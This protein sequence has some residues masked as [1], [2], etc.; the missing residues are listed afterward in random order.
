MGYILPV[1]FNQYQQYQKRVTENSD[2]TFVLPPMKPTP[3]NPYF[4]GE[5][6][7]EREKWNSS[8]ISKEKHSQKF[9][10]ILAELTGKG[11][12]INYYV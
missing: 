11:E 4:T 7:Q 9:D 1:Q 12:N 8:N 10:Q 5:E 2:K 3:I 6:P